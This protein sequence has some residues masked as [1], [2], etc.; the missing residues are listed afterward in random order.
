MKKFFITLIAAL[1]FTT[2]ISFA[3]TTVLT[4]KLIDE[5]SAAVPFANVSVL[6]SADSALAGTAITSAEGKFSVTTPATGKY[7]LRLSSIGFATVTTEVFEVKGIGFSK[8]FGDIILKAE[9]KKLDNVSVTSMRPAITQ[10]ADRLV[11]SVDGTAMA[12]GNTAYAVLAK[13]PGV[14]IDGDGNIQLNGR[15]GIMVMIDG[16][17]TYLSASDLRMVLEAMPAENLKNIEIIT[18]PSSKYSAEGTAGI[19]NLNLKKNTQQ[20]L[21]GN[22]TAA[23]SNNFNHW[24]G[25]LSTSIMYK[26]G[27]WNSFMSGSFG[28]WVNGRDA[29][30]NRIF[31]TPS[32]VTYFD[33][34][35]ESNNV[36]T[37]PPAGRFGTDYSFNANHSVGFIVASNRYNSTSD[38]LTETY[39]GNQPK[40]PSQLV[41]AANISANTSRKL[42][43]NVHYTGKLDS[44][45]T[46]LS[47]DADYVRISNRG[48]SDFYN[49]FNDLNIAQKTQD[50]LYTYNPNGFKVY[51]G[52]IDYMRPFANGGR[53]E[54]GVR[55]SRVLSDNDNRFYFNNGSLIP[56]NQR[57]NHFKYNESIYAAY[58]NWNGRLNKSFTAQAGLRMEH[59]SST[60]NSITLGKLTQRD[61][62][63]LFPTLFLQQKISDNYGINYSASRRITRPNYGSLNPFRAYRDPYTWYEGNPFLQPEYS[64][65]VSM[66]HVIRKQYIITLNYQH[67]NRVI[68]ELPYVDAPNSITVYT[69]ANMSK[70]RNIGATAIAPLKIM[71]N[72]DAQNTAVVSYNKFFLHTD[73]ISQ[74]NAQ[75]FYSLQSNHTILLP[76]ALRMEMSLLYRGPAANGLYDQSAMWR[77]DVA[78]KRS[79]KN[80]KFDAALNVSDIFN[81]FRVKRTV[82]LGQSISDFDQTF[83]MRVITLSLRYNFSKGQKVEQRKTAAVEEVERI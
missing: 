40:T 63:N 27:R 55:A 64:T 34:T 83:R 72:W 53:F 46:T 36:T 14:F 41:T 4:G 30:F 51:S 39:I 10:L 1:S 59:T 80:K 16:K 17:Q 49:H 22:V 48:H 23:Y 21:N 15:S 6:R 74:T 69:Q 76:H 35:A 52:K 20:G 25:V 9:G 29:T 61:Y 26:A 57:S 31:V 32:S 33:Q 79:F 13:A 2:T 75:L 5:R 58:V 62:T 47:A 45:G 56:D 28:R 7:F 77:A 18:N 67:T 73:T 8:N 42:T 19:L 11:V 50:F 37:G 70:S 43:A 71:K 3:Q 12:A 81:S 65:I 66:A 82:T 78:F 38:F 54:A 68:V 60:G 24:A 44:A